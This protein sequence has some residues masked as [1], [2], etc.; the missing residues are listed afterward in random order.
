MRVARAT[1]SAAQHRQLC[2]L[3]TGQ[4]LG[5]ERMRQPA[6]GLGA[7]RPRIPDVAYFASDSDFEAITC[8]YHRAGCRLAGLIPKVDNPDFKVDNKAP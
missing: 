4:F 2:D 1:D 8:S 5:A 6:G 3:V 7:A